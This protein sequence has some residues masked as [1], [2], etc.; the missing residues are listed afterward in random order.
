M[1]PERFRRV[2]KYS[3]ETRPLEGKGGARPCIFGFVRVHVL[4]ITTMNLILLLKRMVERIIKHPKR[5]NNFLKRKITMTHI[6]LIPLSQVDQ[7]L[8]LAGRVRSGAGFDFF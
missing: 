1:S 2:A 5:L 3:R 4:G 7:Y 8:G 6:R